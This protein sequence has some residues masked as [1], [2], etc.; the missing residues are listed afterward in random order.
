MY[1]C[2]ELHNYRFEFIYSSINRI[3][4][5]V[6]GTRSARLEFL[7]ALLEPIDRLKEYEEVGKYYER[8]AFLEIMKTKPQGTVYDYYLINDALI[9]KV[10]F[11]IIQKYA[12][13]GFNNLF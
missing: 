5:Y 13:T 4:A 7:I 11:E 1:E 9:S 3:G 6:V 2:F 10:Y 8:H 12:R